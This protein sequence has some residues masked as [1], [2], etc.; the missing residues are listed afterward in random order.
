MNADGS[1]QTNSPT[2][3]RPTATPAWSPDG[4][5]IA[6]TAT[7]D[8]NFEIYTMNADGSAQTNVT[9]HAASNDHEPAWSPDG[10]KI[11]FASTRD[12]VHFEIYTMNADGSA[13]T[14]VTNHRV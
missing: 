12:S 5:K 9:N 13:Q 3:R 14:A 10:T 6:F 2:T 7:R 4:T 1:A 8:G 11:A